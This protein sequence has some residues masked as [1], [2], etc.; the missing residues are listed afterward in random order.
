MPFANENQRRLMWAKHPEIA[1]RWAEEEKRKARRE[2]IR[3]KA[4][5]K[6]HHR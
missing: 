6:H 4:R 5:R 3:R 2:A 1:R